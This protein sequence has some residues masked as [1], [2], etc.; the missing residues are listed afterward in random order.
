M[1]FLIKKPGILSVIQD[2]G[3][4]GYQSLGISPAGALD[5]RSAMLANQIL[6]NDLNAAVVE[7]NI[8]GLTFE[9]SV[10]TSIATAGA[11]M[12]FFINGEPM[13]IGRGI[14]IAKGDVV[15][16]GNTT[17]NMRT[18]LAVSGG[19]IVEDV[20]GSA[21]THTRSNMGG[22]DGRA[23]Q[24]GDYLIIN[25]N[26]PDELPKVLA[27]PLA[28]ADTII[29]LVKGPNFVQFTEESIEKLLNSSYKITRSNDRMGIRL[30]GEA[31]ATTSGI[32]DIVSEPTQIGN[33]QVPKNG[34]PI[35]LLSDRQTTGGYT[36]IATL[37]K[38]DIPKI[39]QLR[40]GQHIQFELIDLKEASDL[41]KADLNKINNKE[42]L[43]ND[44]HFE[45]H[46]RIK[47]ER[48]KQLL[49]R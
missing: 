32:H 49:L 17:E 23:L 10:D 27:E 7:Q 16:F 29:R 14:S 28:Y 43:K 6:G 38:V 41:Y 31:L 20:L 42:Y 47:A 30:E 13:P 33:V 37:A 24:K 48:V 44:T 5:Y 25:G 12:P 19:F 26:V 34:Q 1:T 18:Y 4:Y 3:R 40:P 39:V 35:I 45:Y 9:S 11:A 46:R 36:R 22:Q 21:A 2:L 8:Q 15:E